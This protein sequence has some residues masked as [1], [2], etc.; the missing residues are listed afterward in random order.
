MKRTADNRFGLPVRKIDKRETN[1]DPD[2]R[3][4]AINRSMA[5]RTRNDSVHMG[6]HVQIRRRLIGLAL[7]LIFGVSAGCNLKLF[8][9]SSED[10]A[11]EKD[12]LRVASRLYQQGSYD[13]A[14][15]LLVNVT[16]RPSDERAYEAQWLLAQAYEANGDFSAALK[17]YK[18][19][20]S[21]F[22]QTAHGT[23]AL[24]KI[25]SLQ[26][27]TSP[28]PPPQIAAGAV[29]LAGPLKEYRLG[30]E[31]ELDI[32]V[33]GDES[34]SKTQTIR[35]DGKIAF[36]LIGDIQAAGLTPDELREKITERLSK[37]LRTP[38]LTV[39]VSQYNS[40]QVYVLGQVKSPG[41]LRLSNDITV[42]QGLARAGGMTDEADLQG[43]LLIRGVQILPVNF[44]RLLRNGDA[45]QNIELHPND[46]I[47]IP[48]VSARKV[49]VLG[50]VN[51]PIAIPLRNPTSLIEA[52]SM[53]GGLT[54]DAESK[55]I[56]IIRGGLESRDMLTVDVDKITK[57]G[58]A[59]KNLMLQP[60]DIVYVPRSFIADVDRFLDHVARVVT[61][62]VL[63]EFGVALYPTVKSVLK[64]GGT[65]APINLIPQPQPR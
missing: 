54:R 43:A 59:A 20:R 15:T 33:Y 10:P 22:P 7:V 58:L 56:A 40:K 49:F 64:T 38:R 60:N 53:A 44:D 3:V 50:E 30:Q 1:P 34:L 21:N 13:E 2:M 24:E 5:S 42:L 25:Q 61:P 32:S 39:V 14:I 18:L 28:L 31:D 63:A 17:E 16:G 37:Y 35:P 65:P 6:E 41:V 52:L 62:I 46:T 47:L 8:T 57:S 11:A 29:P 4:H 12:E 9:R 55:S 48:S 51:L 36:P 45:T 19:I 26:E 23:D 27:T